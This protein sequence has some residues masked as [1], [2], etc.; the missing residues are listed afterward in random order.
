[1]Y[2]LYEKTQELYSSLLRRRD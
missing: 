1:M 2:K